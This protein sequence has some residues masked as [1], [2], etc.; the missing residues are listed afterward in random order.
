MTS[1]RKTAIIIGI[2]FILATAMGVTSGTILGP[3]LLETNYLVAMSEGSSTVLISTIF[4]VIMS[5]AVIAIAVFIYPI[6]NRTNETLAMGYLCAR[7]VEG[8]FIAI[9][10]IA[11]LSIMSLGNEFIEMGRPDGSYY[12]TIGNLL[13][14]SSTSLFTLGAEIVFGL[15]AIILNYFFIKTKLVPR[16]ISIWGFVGGALLLISGIMKIMGVSVFALAVAFTVP[17]AL[18]EMVLAVWLI[19]KGFSSTAD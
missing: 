4:N 6:L 3:L 19:T 15:T 10:G 2:L 12:Q 14:S 8:T 11:W 16:F 1:D 9:A 17:I 18:N 5:G 7:L 13:V